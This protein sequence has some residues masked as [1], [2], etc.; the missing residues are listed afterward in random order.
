MFHIFINVVIGRFYSWLFWIL[1]FCFFSSY[2][3]INIV[4]YLLNI[5]KTPSAVIFLI[6]IWKDWKKLFFRVDCRL[7]SEELYVL[8]LPGIFTH[9]ILLWKIK[10]SKKPK[11]I[12]GISQEPFKSAFSCSEVVWC[13]ICR[14]FLENFAVKFFPMWIQYFVPFI[15]VLK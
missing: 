4:K 10:Y 1:N 5:K 3:V 7:K 13:F 15:F 9:S 6:R 14:F 2:T 11:T 12:S 8:Y